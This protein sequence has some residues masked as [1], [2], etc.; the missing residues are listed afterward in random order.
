[1][2]LTGV[3]GVLSFTFGESIRTKWLVIFAAVFFLI[4]VNIPVL[5]LSVAYGSPPAF[6]ISNLGLGTSLSLAFPL[7]PLLALPFGS[8][9]IVED[10]ESGVLQYLLSNPITKSD[11]FLGRIV[12]LLLATTSVILISFGGAAAAVYASD[13][14]ESLLILVAMEIAVLLNA[15]M[16]AL[17][18]LISEV[19]KRKIT[20]MGTGILFWFLFTTVSSLSTLV[21]AVNYTIGVV[22]GMSI[23]LLDPVETSRLLMVLSANLGRGELGDTGYVASYVITYLLGLDLFWVILSSLVTWFAVLTV[24]GFLVFRRQDAA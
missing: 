16:L 23:V 1:M 20:A 4:A 10:R 21:N 24:L 3:W 12:G 13:T 22:A 19:T 5:L 17:G 2:N 11:F 15:V 7:V 9:S 18:L 6:L 8:I 14:S